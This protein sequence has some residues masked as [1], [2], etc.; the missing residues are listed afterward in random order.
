MFNEM[1]NVLLVLFAVYG[2]AMAAGVVS[3]RSGIVNIG[4]NANIIAGALGSL[5]V[6]GLLKLGGPKASFDDTSFGVDFLG[7]L[8]AGLSGVIVS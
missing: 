4:L 8:I 3:E 1:M 6:H 5:I 2:L 7:I